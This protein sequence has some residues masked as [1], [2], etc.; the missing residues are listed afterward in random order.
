M[1][2]HTISHCHSLA[3]TT[4]I[5]PPFLFLVF[6]SHAQYSSVMHNIPPSVQFLE[7][8]QIL[9]WTPSAVQVI[10]HT[11]SCKWFGAIYG[12]YFRA[13]VV[14]PFSSCITLAVGTICHLEISAHRVSVSGREQ[15]CSGRCMGCKPRWLGWRQSAAKWLIRVHKTL[16]GM[17]TNAI[18]GRGEM[19]DLMGCGVWKVSPKSQWKKLM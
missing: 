2:R 14:L 12:N 7:H 13:A 3:E 19:L 4:T 15:A 9:A 1:S 8:L 10:H 6:L 16:G 11:F 17:L 5:P 18:F